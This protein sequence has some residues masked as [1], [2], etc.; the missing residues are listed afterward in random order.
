MNLEVLEG[1]EKFVLNLSNERF[2]GVLELQFQD[3]ELILIRKQESFKP[4]FLVVV[5]Q[6]VLSH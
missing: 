4:S 3:G 1:L 5:E 2:Y 6:K